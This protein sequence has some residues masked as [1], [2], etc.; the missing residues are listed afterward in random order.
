MNNYN[1]TDQVLSQLEWYSTRIA[2]LQSVGD[3][4]SAN[5]LNESASL[6][7]EAADAQDEWVIV[8]GE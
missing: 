8:E 7:A 5:V 1:I 2:Y 4:K 3:I 6:M